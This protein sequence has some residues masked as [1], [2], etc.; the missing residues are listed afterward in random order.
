VLFA[1]VTLLRIGFV[2]SPGSK[3]RDEIIVGIPMIMLEVKEIE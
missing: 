2:E 3:I 1:C